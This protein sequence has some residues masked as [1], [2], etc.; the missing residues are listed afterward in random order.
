MSEQRTHELHH[1]MRKLSNDMAENYEYLQTRATKDSGTAGDQAEI[2]WANWL[3]EW[4]PPIVL[5]F[6]LSKKRSPHPTRHQQQ[7]TGHSVTKRGL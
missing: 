4:L 5:N 7:Y 6:N 1:F 2:H 3:R